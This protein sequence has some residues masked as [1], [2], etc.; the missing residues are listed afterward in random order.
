MKRAVRT[1]IQIIGVAAVI[2]GVL[3]IVLE[4]AHHQI[5]VRDHVDPIKNNIWSYVIGA[6]LMVVGVILFLGS[7]SLAEQLTDDY[8]DDDDANDEK[9]DAH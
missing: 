6:V 4:I 7:N 5:Q 9:T 8:D 1:L 3:E 2:F